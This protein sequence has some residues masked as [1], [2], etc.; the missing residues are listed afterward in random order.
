MLI[1]SERLNYLLNFNFNLSLTLTC[2]ALFCWK[3]VMFLLV[4]IILFS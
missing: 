2:L 1:H 4:N 3:V